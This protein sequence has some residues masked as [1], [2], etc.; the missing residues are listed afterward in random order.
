[1]SWLTPIAPAAVGLATSGILKKIKSLDK[2]VGFNLRGTVQSASAIAQYMTLD[3]PPLVI[4]YLPFY[5][6]R[7]YE[8]GRS[9]DVLKYRAVGQEF[10]AHQAGGHLSFSAE[11]YLPSNSEGLAKL[12]MLE[13]LHQISIPKNLKRSDMNSWDKLPNINK[14]VIGSSVKLGQTY[15]QVREMMQEERRTTYPIVVREGIILHAYIESLI[16]ERDVRYGDQIKVTVLCRRYSPPPVIYDVREVGGNQ[17][18]LKPKDFQSANAKIAGKSKHYYDVDF[19][20]PGTGFLSSLISHLSNLS[21]R[22][23]VTGGDWVSISKFG[24]IL[25]NIINGNRYRLEIYETEVIKQEIHNNGINRKDV[26]ITNEFF[27]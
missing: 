25:N 11:I 8:F 4:S 13:F 14:R 22:V 20:I 16:V 2:V 27:N 18:S 10:L 6:V 23:F 19:A 1:M 24:E 17:T 7:R 3:K 5:N 15:D 26:K 21:L 9:H 12:S